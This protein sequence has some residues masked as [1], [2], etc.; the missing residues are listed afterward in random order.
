MVDCSRRRMLAGAGVASLGIALGR[1]WD[2]QALAQ[3]ASPSP[4]GD[5]PEV[6]ITATEFHLDLPASLPGGFTKLTLHNQGALGHHAM[7]LKLND[8][9]TV[10]EFDEALESP[11]LG[12][13]FSK[14]TS[15]GGPEVDAGLQASVILDLIPGQ[16]VVFCLIPDAENTPHYMHGMHVPLE[17]TEVVER[18]APIPDANVQLIDFGFGDMPMETTAGTHIWEVTNNGEQI[19]EFLV[20]RQAEGVTYDEIVAELQT[21]PGTPTPAGPPSHWIIG[22]A[23]PMTPGQTNYSILELEAGDYFTICF[24]P[25]PATGAPHFAL[26]MIMP[27][28]VT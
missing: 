14:A 11:D 27:V 22:G 12:A 26:G 17:V 13:I 5:Y 20:M 24:I 9:V 18:P 23:A 21:P 7:F 10:D 1:C 19:H 6:I 3:D 15:L 25:D 16:Y 4:E 8:G 28:T 2:L